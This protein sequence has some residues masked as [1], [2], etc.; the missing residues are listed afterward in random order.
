[1]ITLKNL[2]YKEIFELHISDFLTYKYTYIPHGYLK[3]S[4]ISNPI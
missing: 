1:M 4:W 2:S 3:A